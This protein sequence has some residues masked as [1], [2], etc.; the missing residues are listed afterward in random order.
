MQAF[1]VIKEECEKTD[2]PLP[3]IK[4]TERYVTV[5]ILGCKKYME[6]LKG[7]ASSP[8]IIEEDTLT[9]LV[10]FCSEPRSRKEMMEFMGL[11]NRDHFSKHYIRPL[12]DAG[13][14]QM[15]KPDKPR[16]SDQKYKET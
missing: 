14:I 12:L 9:R 6:L 16:S 7:S 13:R 4:A 8:A 11:T 10:E 2:A 15:T 5:T 3:E 1:I